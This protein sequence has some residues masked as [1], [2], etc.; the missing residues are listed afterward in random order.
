VSS[1]LWLEVVKAAFAAIAALAAGCG[2]WMALRNWRLGEENRKIALENTR[3]ANAN[4]ENAARW[5]RAELAS[6]YLIPLFEDAEL[7]FALRCIDWGKGVIPVPER[8]LAMFRGEKTIEHKPVLVV[9]AMEP[10]LR[11]DVS[12]NPQGMLYRLALDALFTRF[13][14]IG[15]RVSNNLIQ[16]EDVPDLEYW[17]K[18]LADWPYAPSPDKRGVFLTFL[19]AAGYEQTL[20]LMKR[21]GVIAR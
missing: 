17:M 18:S 16:I 15:Y 4:A 5:K 12:S 6:S 2:A 3:I 8:H 11:P 14:W 13:E 10:V 9:Q 1:A 19:R 21:F 7:G 20:E